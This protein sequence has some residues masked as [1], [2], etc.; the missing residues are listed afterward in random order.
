MSRRTNSPRARGLSAVTQKILRQCF[1]F[2][3]SIAVSHL[4]G[5][6]GA[7]SQLSTGFALSAYLGRLFVAI[8][9]RGGQAA[10]VCALQS[11]G[12]GRG[13]SGC[14]S[15][16]AGLEQGRAVST[17]RIIG[18]RAWSW[19]GTVPPVV[20]ACGGRADLGGGGHRI[21]RSS[22]A[23]IAVTGRIQAVARVGRLCVDYRIRGRPGHR[24]AKVLFNGYQSGL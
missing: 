14:G 11:G 1:V 10:R 9:A 23:S 6:W 8:K 19:L 3:S 18:G 13:C 17:L 16:V 24:A 5:S 12:D 2:G 7:C 4:G 20:R 15:V 21:A 22:V